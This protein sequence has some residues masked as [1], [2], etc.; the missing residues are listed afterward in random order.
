MILVYIFAAKKVITRILFFGGTIV[1]LSDAKSAWKVHKDDLFF[2]SFFYFKPKPW[3]NMK[4]LKIFHAGWA[5]AKIRSTLA[6]SKEKFV[7]RWLG[8]RA[9]HFPI[10]SAS[11]SENILKETKMSY[12]RFSIS[13]SHNFEKPSRN[14]AKRTKKMFPKILF[15]FFS[16]KLVPRM[17]SQRGNRKN[18]NS[19]RERKNMRN[20]F[21]QS[22]SRDFKVFI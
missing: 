5:F 6:Q 7:H 13:K 11:A 2:L 8:Q 15:F 4:N 22:R 21:F 20:Y 12:K 10:D 9:D 1:R 3:I 19:R 14:Q 16:S 17:L 18:S